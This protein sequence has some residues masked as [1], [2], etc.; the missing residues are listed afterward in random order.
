M[1]AANGWNFD[2]A[3]WRCSLKEEDL[4]DHLFYYDFVCGERGMRGVDHFGD[5]FP[6]S[7]DKIILITSMRHPILRIIAGGGGYPEN[8]NTDD[9]G[10]DNFGLRK[11]LGNKFGAPITRDDVELAKARLAAFDM[12]VDAENLGSAIPV[13][14]G[15]L[16]W[17][18]KC[19]SGGGSVATEH[20]AK[21]IAF[22][23]D[24]PD[25][26]QKWVRRNAPE[27]EV[28]EYGKHLWQQ[29]KLRESVWGG[30]IYSKHMP[31]SLDTYHD[32][33]E[34]YTWSCS[35]NATGGFA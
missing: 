21:L 4:Q 15:A 20:T 5:N 29:F 18:E 12:V 16:G 27:M 17:T 31:E 24:H 22:Q 1:A 32:M 14:C 25:I 8:P 2:V 11:L 6:C 30:R 34:K 9:C 26:Y 28:Y 13:L 33:S 23:R 7:S 19:E 35:G 10:T 3:P